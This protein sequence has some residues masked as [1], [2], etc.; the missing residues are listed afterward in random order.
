MTIAVKADD[1]HDNL[2]AGTPEQQ[3]SQFMVGVDPFQDP[4]P[5]Q[6][7]EAARKIFEILQKDLPKNQ[8]QDHQTMPK[9]TSPQLCH[10]WGRKLLVIVWSLMCKTPSADSCK[11]QT[12]WTN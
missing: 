9:K 3:Q 6:L 11:A 4:K 10:K 2:E 5:V 12:E 7:F 1:A 8:M